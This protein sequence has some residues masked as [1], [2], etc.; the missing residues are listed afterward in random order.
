MQRLF[1]LSFMLEDGGI[2]PADGMNRVSPLGRAS[3]S[4]YPHTP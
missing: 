3:V 2:Q 4:G 1:I